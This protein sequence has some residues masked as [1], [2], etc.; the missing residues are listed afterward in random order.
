M[1][2][3]IPKHMGGTDDPGNLVELTVEEHA[4]AH[5][6]LYEQ[7][8]KI[9]DKIA[10][11][12]L[13]KQIGKDELLLEKSR[14]GGTRNRGISKTADH[15]MNISKN[16]AGGVTEHSAATKHAISNKMKG[17]CNAANHTSIE[18][19]NKQSDAMKLAWQRRK[20]NSV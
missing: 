8:G 16:A 18:Y 15:K 2:H 1:H 6:I 3:I 12:G 9:E 14:L 11:L 5:R 10:Y 17:N 7:Y 20:N 19:K 4:A 13:E